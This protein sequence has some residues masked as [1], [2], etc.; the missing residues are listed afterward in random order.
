MDGKHVRIVKPTKSGS[1]CF[2][3]KNYFSIV[4]FAVADSNY[5]FLYVDV[6]SY[7][8]ESDSTIFQTS[9][10]SLLLE[11][12]EL[13]LPNAK[14]LPGTIGPKLPF[15]FVADEAFSLSE[16][17]MRPFSGKF[18]SHKKAIFN[19][20]LTRAR[21]FIECAFGILSNKWRIFH[22]AMNVNMDLAIDI[23]KCCC[24]LHNYVRTRD[25][26]MLEDTLSMQGLYDV[27]QITA[28]GGRTVNTIRNTFADYFVS[29]IGKLSWQDSRV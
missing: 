18:L 12:N 2:N 10:F 27:P 19:Y 6:G 20:R 5:E 1:L 29:E 22:R 3:Y 23:V 4:L 16:N 8:R 11:N 24:I 7:G 13:H 26:F 14:P 15:T 28:Q 9:Q 25:R 21:R 17:V